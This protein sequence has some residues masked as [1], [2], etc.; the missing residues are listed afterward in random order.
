MTALC[1]VD[2]TKLNCT[3]CELKGSHNTNACLKKKKAN[4]TKGNSKEREKTKT[5]PKD[6]PQPPREPSNSSRRT[7]STSFRPQT[8][9]QETFHNICVQLRL[10]EE[11][12]SGDTDSDNES[13][14]TP[15]ESNPNDEIVTDDKIED[16]EIDPIDPNTA[17]ITDDEYEQEIS[18]D[19]DSELEE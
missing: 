13:Y 5:V 3:F 9:S 18:E 4:K 16:D 1:K 19:K 14:T 10:K 15:P 7:N 8:S 11:M 6:D 17:E 12:D 2:K